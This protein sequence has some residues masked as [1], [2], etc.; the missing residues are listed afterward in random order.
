MCDV[1]ILDLHHTYNKNGLNCEAGSSSK[2][3]QSRQ[4]LYILM[5]LILNEAKVVDTI[6]RTEVIIFFSEQKKHVKQTYDHF[7]ASLNT[8]VKGVCETI[9]QRMSSV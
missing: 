6:L 7:H 8:C 3:C 4:N 9:V 1:E 5:Y 2:S